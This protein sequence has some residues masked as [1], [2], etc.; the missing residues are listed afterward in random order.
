MTSRLDGKKAVV[1]GA[2]RGIGRA[3]ALTLAREGA[4]VALLART[5]ADLEDAAE[6]IR[7]MGRRAV[8]GVADAS[9][10]EES[11]RALGASIAE[12]GGV[13]ILVANAGLT[14]RSRVL[15]TLPEDIDRILDVD[16]KGTVRCL[17]S[18]GKR[19]IEQGTGGSIIIV[20]SINAIWAFPP[21]AVYSSVKAA[22]ENLS[23]SLAVDL[24]P[25]RIRVNTVAPGAIRTDMN[26]HFT[27][28]L[29][30]GIGDAIPLG[31]VGEPEDV[32]EVVCWVASPAAGYVTGST[33][34]VDGGLML[35]R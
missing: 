30:R 8:I 22:L 1:T 33:L 4:D 2:S 25:H 16:F 10:A 35:R 27:P 18:V 24:A 26:P 29:L 32:A 15:G 11:E 5:R 7:R 20:T 23:R 13:D 34:V 3:V 21:Q 31:R 17:Q 28:E 12:L 9:N 19:M 14:V 6:E